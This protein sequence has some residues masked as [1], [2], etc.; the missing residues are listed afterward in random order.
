MGKGWTWID[1]LKKSGHFSAH[2]CIQTKGLIG[3]SK[4]FVWRMKVGGVCLSSARD[5]LATGFDKRRTSPTY[6]LP[7]PHLRTCGFFMCK[8]LRIPSFGKLTMNLHSLKNYGQ[9]QNCK[10]TKTLFTFG[11]WN[12]KTWNS[13]FKK[14]IF[15]IYV[16]SSWLN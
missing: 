13:I 6:I 16:P 14:Q 4:P 12:D 7:A 11:N 5:R 2:I 1:S 10:T 9:L 3:M 15:L 8:D